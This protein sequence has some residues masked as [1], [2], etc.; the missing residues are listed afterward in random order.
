MKLTK[1]DYIVYLIDCKGYTEEESRQYIAVNGVL[2]IKE[3]VIK[4]NN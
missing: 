3:Q 4:Y 1:K 2:E